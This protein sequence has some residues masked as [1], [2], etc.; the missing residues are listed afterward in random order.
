[1]RK[2]EAGDKVFF[3]VAESD[4]ETFSI[5]TTEVTYAS[6]QKFEVE[7]CYGFFLYVNYDKK[8]E[9]YIGEISGEVVYELEHVSPLRK[10]AE[11]NYRKFMVMAKGLSPSCENPLISVSPDMAEVSLVHIGEEI[12]KLRMIENY[13]RNYVNVTKDLFS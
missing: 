1:M 3:E 13:V 12:K 4:G 11:Y 9:C 10:L 6:Q 7:G 8:R 5:R 2:F